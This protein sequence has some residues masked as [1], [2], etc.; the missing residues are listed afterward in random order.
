MRTLII[1]G[2]YPEYRQW[3]HTTTQRSVAAHQAASGTV[4]V[5]GPAMLHQSTAGMDPSDVK[6]MFI[7]T[8]Q[9]R[10]DIHELVNILAWRTNGLNKT[11]LDVQRAL[12]ALQDKKDALFTASRLVDHITTTYRTFAHNNQML[13]KILYDESSFLQSH[14]APNV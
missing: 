6:G 2:N 13:D 12:E 5:E 11:I 8:W 10:K 7:G 9:D 1:A 3:F 4:Y 14:V